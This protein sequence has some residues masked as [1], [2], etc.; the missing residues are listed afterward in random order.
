MAAAASK[1]DPG[2]IQRALATLD[3]SPATLQFPALTAFLEH[4]I[5]VAASTLETALSKARNSTAPAAIALLGAAGKPADI[6]YLTTLLSPAHQPEITTAALDALARYD[7]P[8]VAT[9]ITDTLPTLSRKTRTAALALLGSRHAWTRHLLENLPADLDPAIRSL[10]L[11]HPDRSLRDLARKKLTAHSPRT[12]VIARYTPGLDKPG[13]PQKGQT[14]FRQLCTACHALDGH[15]QNIG[16]DLAALTDRSPAALLTAIL[17]PNAA[18]E[19]KYRTAV[20]TTNDNR[21][22][23]G[24]LTGESATAITLATLD[25]RPQTILRNTLESLTLTPKSLMPEGLESAIPPGQMT[26]LLAYLAQAR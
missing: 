2:A 16:P 6:P 21:Q 12:P 26:H 5:E 24:T 15:G 14:L 19:D 9:T 13:D 20:A 7:S 4:G 23:V 11:D 22:L 10:L 18:V 8:V 3:N 25:G 1:D 17:D